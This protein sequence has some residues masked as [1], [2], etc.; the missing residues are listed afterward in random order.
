MLHGT[1]N[2]APFLGRNS[3]DNHVQ[4]QV[5]PMQSEEVPF[6]SFNATTGEVTWLGDTGMRRNIGGIKGN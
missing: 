6:T 3:R 5:L 4:V 1:V 2:G